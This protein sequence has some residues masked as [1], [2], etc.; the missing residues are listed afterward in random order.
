MSIVAGVDSSTQSC[1]VELRDADTG[2]L[3]GTGRAPHPVTFPPV[4]QQHPD[5]WWRAF[6]S[7]FGRAVEDAG[8]SAR[9]IGAI[10]VAAQCHG[11]VLLGSNGRP[12]RRAKLWNDTESAPQAKQMVEELGSGAWADAIGSVPTAAFTITKL[13]WIAENEPYLL[14][15]V[16][17]I[18][19]PHDYLTYRLA[20]RAVTDR[21]DASGTGYYAA[22]QGRWRVDL[23]DQFVA[24]GLDWASFLPEVLGPNELAGRILPDVAASF[25][26]RSDVI[27]GPGAGDQHAGALG[28]GVREGD[29]VYSLGTSGVVFTESSSPVFDH[30]GDVDGV[31]DAAGGYLPLACTLNST[32]VTDSV[33]RWLGVSLDE[34]AALALEAPDSDDRPVFLAYLDG[35]RTPNRPDATGLLGGLTTAT[36]RAQIAR[37]AFEGVLF[38]IVS[39][40]DAIRSA[41]AP[42]DGSVTAV[43][44]G[45][46][47]P[48]YRQFLADILQTPVLTKDLSEATA[49]GACIQAA[50]VLAVGDVAE[51]RDAWAPATTTSTPPREDRYGVTRARYRALVD[52][53]GLARQQSESQTRV[54][55]E[56]L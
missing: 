22:H 41:G 6:E 13:A 3:R 46:K 50:A 40:H 30:R 44:G 47:S 11:L 17:K 56:A 39:G 7:A 26:L 23:L 36:T 29:V 42:A 35:E 31:A 21:S 24:R 28:V 8:V 37:A 48:A 12:L 49:R 53:P 55:E 27:V 10:S 51:V 54:S 18:L 4:S 25:G 33:A 1:T 43:G 5:D 20:G 15:M 19:V 52:G 14:D 16:S 2:M 38:G 9:E 34:L 32:K 45:S